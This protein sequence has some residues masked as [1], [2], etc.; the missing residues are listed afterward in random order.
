[1]AA[2]P[3]IGPGRATAVNGKD[4]GRGR[5]SQLTADNFKYKTPMLRNV[6][7][8]A[9]YGHD[10][11]YGTLEAVVRHHLDPVASL[12]AYDTSQLLLPP[13]IAPAA[14]ID[15]FAEHNNLGNRAK[16]A[17]ANE[18]LPVSLTEQQLSQLL[19]F[20]RALTDPSSI[21]QRRLIPRE[22]PSGLP[23]PD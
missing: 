22:V 8:T 23:V 10:G 19:D 14:S 7:L 3:Q 13:L 11:A 9:P 1:V 20:L 5:V 2:I 6:E 17:A 18:L 16:R 12:N 4:L 21:D 15:D